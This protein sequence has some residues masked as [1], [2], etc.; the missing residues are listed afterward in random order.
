MAIKFSRKN[1]KHTRTIP[2][3]IFSYELL[4]D[5]SFKQSIK[6]RFTT[7][8]AELLISLISF[9]KEDEKG[10]YEAFPNLK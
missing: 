8:E 3:M 10:F 7:D 9:A 4:D 5:W 6:E 2:E 1:N